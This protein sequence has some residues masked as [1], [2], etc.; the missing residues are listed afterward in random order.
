MTLG[1]GFAR[2]LVELH[3]VRRQRAALPGNGDMADGS[4]MLG[5]LVVLDSVGVDLPRLGGWGRL[6]SGPWV[7]H[8]RDEEQYWQACDDTKDQGSDMAMA[9][10]GG[11][12]RHTVMGTLSV[13][14]DSDRRS[15]EHIV[16]LPQI[17]F[18]N[19]GLLLLK[20]QYQPESVAPRRRIGLA[21]LEK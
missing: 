17:K 16:N 8:A 12:E 20:N 6:V 3:T 15:L 14:S 21:S 18:F 4:V 19:I 10:S 11:I 13:L 5:C 1:N 2:F 7:G 9:F